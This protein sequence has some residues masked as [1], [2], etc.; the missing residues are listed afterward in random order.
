[1]I[2]HALISGTISEFADCNGGDVLY[3]LTTE[4]DPNRKVRE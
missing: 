2:D 4:G 3:L 1:M